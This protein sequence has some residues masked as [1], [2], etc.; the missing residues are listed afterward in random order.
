MNT[1][2]HDAEHPSALILSDLADPLLSDKTKGLPRGPVTE[3]GEIP[4]GDNDKRNAF[5]CR[6]PDVYDIF[7]C[8][9]PASLTRELWECG[10][11]GRSGSA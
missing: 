2:Y 3:F 6:H 1:I 8:E 5:S 9:R 4:R 10:D 7:W 11:T